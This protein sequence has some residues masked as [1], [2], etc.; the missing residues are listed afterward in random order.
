MLNDIGI[1]RILWLGGGLDSGRDV[2]NHLNCTGMPGGAALR[3]LQR[4]CPLLRKQVLLR[5]GRPHCCAGAKIGM[6]CGA[7]VRGAAGGSRAVWLMK[8]L[9][10]CCMA[11][12]VVVIIANCCI[13]HLCLVLR[14]ALLA[15]TCCIDT[16][17]V[18]VFTSFDAVNCIRTDADKFAM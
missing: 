3:G 8:F 10:N 9:A 16:W 13:M 2:G 17:K 7:K 18:A 12:W 14:W 11:G 15:P 6:V 5:L 1:A 4:P